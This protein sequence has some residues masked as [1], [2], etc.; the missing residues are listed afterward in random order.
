[1]NS[2]WTVH[3]HELVKSIVSRNAWIFLGIFPPLELLRKNIE[4]TWKNTISGGLPNYWS[5]KVAFALELGRCWEISNCGFRTVSTWGYWVNCLQ[6]PLHFAS[7]PKAPAAVY[8]S[9][10]QDTVMGTGLLEVCPAIPF[11]GEWSSFAAISHCGF[12]ISRWECNGMLHFAQVA[13]AQVCY[14]ETPWPVIS[15]ISIKSLAG[16]VA[17]MVRPAAVRAP[18]LQCTLFN[19]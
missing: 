18:Q 10:S 9:I 2:S 6:R 14:A 19:I 15:V 17:A 16:Q 3:E 7:N 4:K 12:Y 5:I 11:L 8:P 1:M 13:H